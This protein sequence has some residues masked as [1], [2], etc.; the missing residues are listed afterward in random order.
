MGIPYGLRHNSNMIHEL[1]ENLRRICE[2]GEAYQVVKPLDGEAARGLGLRVDD[3]AKYP[4]G[5]KLFFWGDMMDDDG[6]WWVTF[7]TDKSMVGQQ[8]SSNQPG[9]ITFTPVNYKSVFSVVA[10]AE[11]NQENKEMDNVN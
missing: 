1:Y 2:A 3:P 9:V 7:V 11:D 10:P 4:V 6:F 8:V 5:T